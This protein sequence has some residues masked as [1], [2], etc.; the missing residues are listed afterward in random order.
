LAKSIKKYD[1]LIAFSGPFRSFDDNAPRPVFERGSGHK[2]A[3]VKAI[4][5]SFGR[6]CLF[7][8]RPLKIASVPIFEKPV[9]SK[10]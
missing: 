3:C 5:F 10:F 1:H 6:T 9:C 8:N 4:W 2:R 7:E